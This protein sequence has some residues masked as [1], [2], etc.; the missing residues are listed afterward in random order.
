MVKWPGYN[1][2]GKI[3]YMRRDV[4]FYILKNTKFIYINV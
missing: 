3:S 4:I 2:W 1:I